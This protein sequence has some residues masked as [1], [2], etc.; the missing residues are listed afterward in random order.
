[1]LSAPHPTQGTVA[2]VLR[3]I[4]IR[5]HPNCSGWEG[6]PWHD[7]AAVQHTSAG[8][9]PALA[10]AHLGP[11]F[12]SSLLIAEPPWTAHHI[13]IDVSCPQPRG[14]FLTDKDS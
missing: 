5:N 11:G 8:V 1:M 13:S 7:T 9:R 12:P 2:A 14:L 10:H 3:R 4:G 6:S